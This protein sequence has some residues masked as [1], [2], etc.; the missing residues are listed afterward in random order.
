MGATELRPDLQGF[1][2][3]AQAG[4]VVPVLWE[5]SS[6]L[7]TPISLFAK[8]RPLG[9]AYLLE[10]AEQ[11]G[12]FGRY[13]FI[14]LR[15]FAQ[16]EADAREVR[17]RSGGTLEVCGGSPLDVLRDLLH[18]YVPA[19]PAG[20]PPFWGG[21][22]GFFGYELIHHL[23]EVPRLPDDGS[24]W[25]EAAFVLA[26]QVVVIDHFRHRLLIV[27]NAR[28]G[29]APLG[30]A[31]EPAY[32][33]ALE[34]IAEVHAAL[35][36]PMPAMPPLPLPA[37]G[38]TTGA[39]NLTAAE[40]AA[41]VA[42]AREHIRIGD[43]FQ[44]VLS[45]RLARPFSGDPLQVYRVLRS[46]NPSPY[47]FLLDFGGY[48]LVGA[49]PEMLVR[50]QDGVVETRPIAGTRP[51]GATAEEDAALE[52]ELRADPKEVA[53]HVM[54]VDLGR[55]DI[56]RVAVPGSM[57]V[58]EQ[59]QVE[60]FS[61][62]MHLVSG[63]RGRLRADLDAFSALAACFPAGTLTGA[64]KVRAMEIIAAL[65]PQRRGPYGGCVAYFGFGGNADT[66]ICIR[67]L[68]I[69]DGVASVQ[70]GGGI[71]Y[72]SQ[73]DLEYQESL[74]KA[75]A[76]LRALEAVDA[77]GSA[78]AGSGGAAAAAAEDVEA[79]A[80]AG[81]AGAGRGGALAAAAPPGQADRA[82]GHDGRRASLKGGAGR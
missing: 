57:C 4:N 32:R 79:V 78:G 24:D 71:V 22:V 2:T 39:A 64:P 56:G 44:V 29:E 52:A 60:R 48:Q 10:S 3:L 23:E 12:R 82:G 45:Q 26:E 14:G 80:A 37:A 19:A 61:H 15:P 65:E 16:L 62:V 36:R 5:G 69:K 13:S 51:R 75:S 28:V 46:S 54:L 58:P 68:A 40:H 42:T 6:D 35:A 47:M 27:H 21:A 31:G 38:P 53:E 77:A 63:V 43:I 59:L 34:A 9:A 20:L 30:D 49:S 17:V 7:E 50:V 70:A 81:S 72:D 1:L 25:P 33:R 76:V 8:L 18:R 41:M 67:T 66:A 55:N 73:A 11:D 74:N